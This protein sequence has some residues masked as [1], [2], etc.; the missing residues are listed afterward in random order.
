MGLGHVCAE[1]PRPGCQPQRVLPWLRR[2]EPRGG[3][4]FPGRGRGVGTAVGK[5]LCRLAV[6]AHSLLSRGSEW[7]PQEA[8]TELQTRVE[9]QPAGHSVPTRARLQQGKASQGLRLVR[10]AKNVGIAGAP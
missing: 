8:G 3:Q 1:V 5:C 9:E 4:S 6:V 7:C 10:R 2:M